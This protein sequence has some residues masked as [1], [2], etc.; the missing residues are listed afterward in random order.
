MASAR[1]DTS[2][3]LTVAL[4]PDYFRHAGNIRGNDWCATGHGF[5]RGSPNPS[6]KLGQMKAVAPEYRAGS[7]SGDTCPGQ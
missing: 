7:N 3:G 4:H 1:A 2:V 5:E 6:I